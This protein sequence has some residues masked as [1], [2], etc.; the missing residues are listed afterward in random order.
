MSGGASGDASGAPAPAEGRAPLWN[1]GFLSLL[2]T[3]FFEASSDNIIKT[4]ITLALAEGKRWDGLLGKGGGGIAGIAFTVPFILLS[5]YGG[6]IADRNSKRTVT[7]V[8]KSCSFV[9]AGITLWAFGAGMVWGALGALVLFAVI[10]AFFGPAKYG[11]IAELVAP[12][13]IARANGVVNMATN[14]AVIV[15]VLVAG[16]VADDWEASWAQ[17]H[18]QG[19]GAWLPGLVMLGFVTA[20]FL[21]C[22]TLPPLRAQDPDLPKQI[23]PFATYVQTL[24]EMSRGPLLGVAGSWA[25]FYFVAAVVLLQL[26][27]YGTFL[28]VSST[29]VSVLMGILGVSIGVGCVTA[30]WLDRP[31][32]RRRF[33]PAGAVA[34]GCGF[35]LLGIA[36]ASWGAT[37]ALLGLT[38]LFA[39]FYIIP[40]Q[41]LLQILSPDEAR[42]RYLGTANGLSFVAGAIGS[43]MFLA[44]RSAGMPSERIFLVLAGLCLAMAFVVRRWLRATAAQ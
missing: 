19:I 8:L 38:G 11:M 3:Q 27:D 39:G 5:A 29:W 2:A 34:L 4:L 13:E 21:T 25:F 37:A 9:V 30:A 24:R 1:R 22:I 33:V 23:N 44:L 15:G 41:S 31:E 18:P 26:P 28:G 17:G 43:G 6:R 35:G 32:R 12:H 42:G 7:I 14:V 16:L 40:L 20:G 36:P 10:S